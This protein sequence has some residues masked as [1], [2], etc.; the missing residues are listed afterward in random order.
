[1]GKIFKFKSHKSNK[2]NFIKE[3]TEAIGD[4]LFSGTRIEIIGGSEI[5]IDGCRK[6]L[7]YSD[8]YIRLKLKKKC[9]LLFGSQLNVVTFEDEAIK[10]HG[11]ISSLEFC[12]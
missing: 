2:I 6:I 12:G 11:N 4:N 8:N 3:N 10:I 5:I 7:D 1:M 9:I